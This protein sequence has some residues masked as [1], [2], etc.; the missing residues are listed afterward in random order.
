MKKINPNK[1]YHSKW[2]AVQPRNKEKHFMV[3]QLLRDEE[4]RVVEVI[5]EAIHSQREII[6]PWHELK[7]DS[8]W[9]MGW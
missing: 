7:D 2:T 6:L 1:L 5:I 3:T 8:V 4:E 9:K